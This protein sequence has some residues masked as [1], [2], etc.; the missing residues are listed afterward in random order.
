M[1]AAERLGEIDQSD[2]ARAQPIAPTV[3]LADRLTLDHDDRMELGDVVATDMSRGPEGAAGPACRLDDADHAE[4]AGDQLIAFVGLGLETEV[5]S[6]QDRP[7]R[8]PPELLAAGDRFVVGPYYDGHLGQ[9]R[10]RRG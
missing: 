9:Y 8:A 6:G 2:I 4:I 10:R 7:G 1:R 5:H 3:V